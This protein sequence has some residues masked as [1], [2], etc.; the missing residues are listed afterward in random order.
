ML[1]NRAPPY[2]TLLHIMP[3]PILPSRSYPTPYHHILSIQKCPHGQAVS[4]SDHGVV[5]S[6]PAGGQI[7]PEPKRCFIAQRISYS[8]FNCPEMTK[9]LL[10]GRKTLT[11]PSILSIR[12]IQ[13]SQ[14][15]L[16]FTY[17][18]I[19]PCHTLPYTT[20]NYIT[21][22]LLKL[23]RNKRLRAETTHFIRPNRPT[24]RW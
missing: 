6:N 15:S 14:V 5:G 17:Y 9:I 13:V 24:I 2:P 16:A 3:Y 10:K 20:L 7:L 22:P 8:H 18:S 11:H 21:L 23:D 12:L 19:L 4:T 1:P